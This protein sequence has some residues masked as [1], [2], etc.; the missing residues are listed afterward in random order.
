M[1][2][3]V[4]NL[5]VTAED[6]RKRDYGMVN[7]L[8]KL[9]LIDAFVW[10]KGVIHLS[11]YVM[12]EDETPGPDELLTDSDE[13]EEEKEELES[14]DDMSP[15]GINLYCWLLSLHGTCGHVVYCSF[16]WSP[17]VIGQA[18]IFLP[19]GFY[20]LLSFFSSPNLSGRRL[21]VYHISTH[22]VALVRI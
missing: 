15:P 14:D 3:N 20:L 13:E 18:I 4:I 5:L 22:G 1:L 16:L 12:P 9:L 6:W 19:C 7:T 10:C 8:V 2:K 11:G 17:Y 21:D